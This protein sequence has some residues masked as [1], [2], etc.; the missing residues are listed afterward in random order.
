MKIGVIA[1]LTGSSAN[2]GNQV[3]TGIM[4]AAAAPLQIVLEDSR[5]DSKTAL[6]AYRKLT[7]MD[8]VQ[9]LISVGGETCEVLNRAAQHDHLV[10]IA[11]GCNTA[12]FNEPESYSFRLD[13]NEVVAAQKTAAFLLKE[14]VRSIA[15][16]NIEN[17]WG[18]TVAKFAKEAFQQS[19]IKITDHVTFS[20]ST[21]GELHTALALIK[22]H[23]PDRIFIVASPETLALLLRQQQ[24]LALSIPI[25]STIAVENPEIPRLAGALADGIVY[26]SVKPNPLSKAAYADFFARHGSAAT[27]AAWG[28]DAILLLKEAQASNSAVDWLR[29]VKG[30]VGAF[31][32]YNYDQH[33]ELSLPYEMRKI[34]KGAFISLS[35]I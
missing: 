3:K 2:F 16:F 15:I 27:F 4:E 11:V 35:D 20:E 31:N 12:K 8:K 10:H 25:V 30:F 19:Q 33:G 21:A 5:S 1:P 22:A 28:H 23:A 32:V 13:V 17:N 24:E 29:H 14:D 34:G 26:V 9:Y 18:A 7:L 6:T